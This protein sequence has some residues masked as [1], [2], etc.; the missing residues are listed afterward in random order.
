MSIKRPSLL[1]DKNFDMS[2][3]TDVIQQKVRP[4]RSSPR[5]QKKGQDFVRP[6]PGPLGGLGSSPRSRIQENLESLN[7]QKRVKGLYARAQ[8][9]KR[10]TQGTDT[11]LAEKSPTKNARRALGSLSRGLRL[12][13]R[14]LLFG[15][16]ILVG[17]LL[18]SSATPG[19]LSLGFPRGSGISLPQSGEIEDLLRTYVE[20]PAQDILAGDMKSPDPLRFTALSLTSRSI[21]RGDTISEIARGAGLNMDTLVS[22]NKIEDVRRIPVG[23]ALKIPNQNGI[24]YSVR[25]G[26]SLSTISRTFNVGMNALADVNNLESSV[27][28]P[29]QDLFIP[30][31]RMKPME[32]KKVLGELFIFPTLGRITSHFGPRNDPFTGVRRFHNG[33]D[34]AAPMD[35]PINAAMAGRVVKVDVH[36]TYGRYI[37]LSHPSGYQTWYAH[38]NRALVR[39]GATVAQG[40]LIGRMGN[41]GYSTGPHLHFSVFKNGS[42]VD[43]LKFLR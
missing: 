6:L 16:L 19:G 41:T 29:G 5:V 24:L 2:M 25:R 17:I 22:L 38:L 9:L 11:P 4:R 33:I 10:E 36:P 32:L 39:V 42:P 18:L 8:K 34:I 14:S 7:R 31:A 21:G 27:I 15:G 23:A 40:E 35:T 26:D 1:V 3:M 28:H 20:P 12:L 30:G 43:P 37:I 13:F